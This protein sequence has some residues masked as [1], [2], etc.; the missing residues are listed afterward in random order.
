MALTGKKAS[1]MTNV[2]SLTPVIHI[3]EEKCVSCHACVT[4]CPVKFCNIGTGA[5]LRV[6]HDTCIG[7][8]ACVAACTHNARHIIDDFPRFLKALDEKKPLVVIVAP[9]IV[10]N[11][12]DTYRRILGWLRSQGVAAI[13]DVGFGAE[14]TV[15]S[16]A[17][18]METETPP[19]LISQPCP[20]IVSFLEIHHPEL[21]PWLAPIGS[22]MQHT[23]QMIRA[24]YPQ[25]ADAEIAAI[26]PCIAKRRE[27]DAIGLGDYV[28]TF[29]A[30]DRYFRGHGIDLSRFPESDFDSPPAERAV[31]F[32]MPG[33]LLKATARDVENI[34]DRTRVIEGVGSVYEYLKKLPEMI[35]LG[36]NPLLIDCLNC[37]FGCNAG[38]AAIAGERSPDDLEWFVKKRAKELRKQHDFQSE[39]ALQSIRETIAKFWQPGMNS[40]RYQDLSENITWKTPSEE[41]IQAIF[42]TRLAKTSVK[43][44]L[45]CGGC[46]YNSCREMAIA[47]YNNL[48]GADHCYV[49]QQR[50]LID[51]ERIIA[52]RE[53][54]LNGILDVASDGYIAFSNR[55]NVVTHV[56]EEFLEMWGFRDQPVLGQHT[57]YLHTLLFKQI[58]DATAFRES[59]RYFISTLEP[60]SGVCELLNGRIVAWYAIATRIGDGD[61]IRVWRYRDI[62]ELEKHR[63]HLEQLVEERT[64]ELSEAKEAAESGSKAK[65]VFLANM[66]HEIRTPLNGVIGLSDLLLRSELLPKQQHYVNL[67]RSSGESLLSLINDIL[68]FSKIEAG[69]FELSHE[70]FDLHQLLDVTLGI[71]ASRAG[72]K[73][74]EMC[75]TCEEPTPRKLIGDANRLRQVILNLL[76][77]AIKFTEKGGVRIHAKTL[78]RL[79]KT[80]E[81]NFDV[82]DTGIGIPPDKMHRLFKDFSQADSS[83]AR[84]HGG[85]GLG[86]VISQNLVRLMGGVIQVESRVGRGTRFYFNARFEYDGGT[87]Q[88]DDESTRSAR[89]LHPFRETGGRFSLAGK[90]V[91]IVDD[92]DMQR[93]ALADQLT[94]WNMNVRE[95]K[96]A[97]DA[98][99]I[100]V[101][102]HAG[103]KAIDL[104]LVDASLQDASGTDLIDKMARK[105]SIAATPTLLLVPLD[106]EN[107]N[108]LGNLSVPTRKT[109]RKPV[110]CSSLHDAILTLLF[111]DEIEE[112]PESKSG[113][114]YRQVTALRDGRK[115]HVLVAEDNRINQI[116]VT[117]MLNEAGLTCDVVQNGLEAYQRFMGGDYDL[118]LM[119]CQMPQVD[120]YEAT[121]MIRKWEE[122]ES[123]AR[124]PIIA[125]TANA[126]SGDEQKCLD[127]GMD[128]YCSKPIN[129]VGLFREIERFTVL[130]E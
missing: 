2:K 44:E 66:S 87:A 31:L 109:L 30:L 116:V 56:N 4:V 28:V 77:N 79:E 83:T 113:T 13:F 49:W 6:D 3:E 42:R 47:I 64:A 110:S 19:V 123:R 102:A 59:L 15:Q 26:S 126:V 51:R 78:H 118:I 88:S 95:A 106:D 65:S 85:T 89:R 45:N 86:L 33:G 76:G 43:D 10:A 11:F 90:N 127:A 39:S 20:V 84:K 80:V 22:P 72:A 46:G 108:P 34:E 130:S 23:M 67:V 73:G 70:P 94:N 17:K 97:Q 37:E 124:T 35:R 29:L 41:E 114:Y 100:L 105:K 57:D 103:K 54:L 24:F 36:R 60:V 75:Y 128:A 9:S 91:L 107:E 18:Y 55:E 53:S 27:F 63:E 121:A 129:P 96:T 115:I 111:P 58:R 68:D 1:L 38:P 112:S 93:S 119:D 74:L 61:V 16:Y 62:T 120:G 104:L 71:L 12:P 5:A 82:I 69:K 40:R 101:E 52:E 125:L 99:S 92:N 122:Q 25:Y 14:L 50:N 8:G 98:L 7:C 48:M 117:G 81:L 32:P 21:L